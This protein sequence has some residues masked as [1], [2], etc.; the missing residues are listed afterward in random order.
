MSYQ[1]LLKWLIWLKLQKKRI[2]AQF[3]DDERDHYLTQDEI[4]HV[5]KDIDQEIV[6]FDPNDADSTWM[7]VHKLQ[8][9]GHLTFYKDK[10]DLPPE[11]SGLTD[12]VFALC[13]QTKFQI[14][15]FQE[16]GYAFLGID[17]THNVMQYKGILLFTIMARDHWG[18]G[19]CF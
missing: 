17:A 14:E 2:R 11:G 6:Q 1:H 15:A 12:D 10:Q 7:W 16:L 5:R 18:H 19:L 4:S 9:Q 3:S 8:A 13:I